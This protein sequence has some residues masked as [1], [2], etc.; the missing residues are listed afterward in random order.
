MMPAAMTDQPFTFRRRVRWGE[1]DPAGVVYTPRF[2]DYAA[3]AFN[4]FL[5]FM[6]GKPLQDRQRELD[7][8]MP[9]KAMQFVFK[10]SVWPDQVLDIQVRV[11]GIRNR[12]FDLAM[13]AYFADEAE[14][15]PVFGAVLSLICVYSAVRESRQIPDA[16]REKLEHY[17]QR[18]PAEAA[19]GP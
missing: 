2:S 1:C 19:A 17:R 6:I 11:S 3:E 12:S 9:A 16:L 5:E 10:R 4:D 13:D 7:V 8:L 15:D 18:F 14:G